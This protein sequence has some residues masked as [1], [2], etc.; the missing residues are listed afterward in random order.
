L[1][2]PAT[3]FADEWNAESTLQLSINFSP[4]QLMENE[5]TIES[6]SATAQNWSTTVVSV[7]FELFKS[8]HSVKKYNTWL[9]NFV[10]SV[11]A[12]PL[13]MFVDEHSYAKLRPLR[14][15]LLTKFYIVKN[16]WS[17]LRAVEQ[18]RGLNYTNSYLRKQNSLD[19]EKS[20]HN[21]ELYILWNTKSFVLSKVAD[22]NPFNSTFFLYTDAG[23]FR[24][25]QL[26]NWP[27]TRFIE[28]QLAPRLRDRI[29]LGQINRQGNI[30]HVRALIQGGFYGG[31][32]KAV[33]D[34]YS[35]FFSLHDEWLERGLFVGKD[36]NIMACIVFKSHNHTAVRLQTWHT[37]CN[38]FVKDE[39]FVYQVSLNF[40]L[41][42]KKS[43]NYVI[44]FFWYRIF[45]QAFQVTTATRNV[46]AGS[47]SQATLMFLFN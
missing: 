7:Y 34:F 35:N 45:S 6:P 40:F 17:I 36:Q 44:Y 2:K 21:P 20:I 31:S 46:S 39:W 32:R 11:T 33:S 38:G 43:N 1:D 47:L 9:L 30:R 28:D 27:D 13:V 24:E 29:L 42:K 16:C 41:I 23:A 25:K 26:D 22:L 14:Q 18:E 15:N 4:E 37:K 19:P 5:V 3:N 8:K 12:A 10:K